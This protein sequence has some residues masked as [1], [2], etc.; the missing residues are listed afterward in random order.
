MQPDHGDLAAR[1]SRDSLWGSAM[2][3]ASSYMFHPTLEAPPIMGL[4]FADWRQGVNVF[5]VWV[6]AVGND[7][8]E[9]DIRVAILEGDLPGATPGYTV[10]ISP[11]LHE[12]LD[13]D[14]PDRNQI[15]QAV[16]M[17][18]QMGNA[19]DMMPRFKEQAAKHGEYM[20]APVVQHDDGQA[21]MNINAGIMKHELI[22]RRVSEIGEDE[23]DM[24]A[25][26][27]CTDE[28]VMARAATM[29]KAIAD[30]QMKPNT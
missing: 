10:R 20:I 8:G 3:V 15:G 7:D 21:Y 25:L 26:K 12:F 17:H 11:S 23:P 28:A 22:V 14:D 6:D 13:A 5:R 18:P 30:Q 29:A 27:S 19:P 1:F 4:V 16:R 2:W 24:L 9:D